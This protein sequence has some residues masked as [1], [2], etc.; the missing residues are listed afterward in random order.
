ME[1]KFVSNTLAGMS[2]QSFFVSDGNIHRGRAYVKIFS[3]GEFNYSLFFTNTT[4]S[5]FADGSHSACNREIAPWE[6]LSVKVG[7]VNECTPYCATEPSNFTDVLFE[8]KKE[9]LVGKGDSFWSDEFIL[10]AEK[11]EY[12]CFDITYR[13]NEIPCHP[14]V[15]VPT[16]EYIDGKWDSFAEKGADKS[17]VPLPS[18][19]GC[20]K[21]VKQRIAYIGDSITQGIGADNN[22]YSHWNAVLSE[23]LGDDNAYWNLGVGYA[24]CS[25]A[26]RNGVWL[27]KAKCNDVVFLCLGV[28]SI[29][30]GYAGEEVVENLLKIVNILKSMGKKVIIQSVPPFDYSGEY[31][32][33][34]EYVNSRI[35]KEIALLCDGYFDNRPILSKS[36][37]ESYRA[38]YG[39]HPDNEGG[40]KWGNA[41]YEYIKNIL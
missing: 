19:I 17:R 27:D 25:D 13:G 14:E 10:E 2:N 41:I 21:K 1:K 40:V 6:I 3:G 15:V 4:D 8:G 24:R 7:T 29:L 12:L 33:T 20:D 23:R 38:L 32:K 16:F 9:K 28:N 26:A 37:E 31:I 30:R 18:M 34:W 35:E 22:S 36:T 11:D 5:T 39:G